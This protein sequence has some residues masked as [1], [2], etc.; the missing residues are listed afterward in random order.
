MSWLLQFTPMTTCAVFCLCCNLAK[1]LPLWHKQQVCCFSVS[2][3]CCELV[4]SVHIF[5]C[6]IFL[7]SSWL[8][9]GYGSQCRL[10]SVSYTSAIY[11]SIYLA[12]VPIWPSVSIFHCLPISF[13][14]APYVISVVA[15]WL[16]LYIR[17]ISCFR[18][19]LCCGL[20]G[21]FWVC[22]EWLIYWYI[23]S[24]L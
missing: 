17:Y 18:R 5:S 19:S 6:C 11:L 20:V 8:P 3:H 16:Y 24:Q 14:T 22:F 4:A 23:P 10:L 1:R 15:P 9:Y 12:H 21:E 13:I 2:Q 7:S